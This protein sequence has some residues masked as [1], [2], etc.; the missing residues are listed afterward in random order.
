MSIILCYLYFTFYILYS[1]M[2]IKKCKGDLVILRDCQL[3][4][5]TLLSYSLK[6]AS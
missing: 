3:Y 5:K 2:L 1:N 6:M 4:I